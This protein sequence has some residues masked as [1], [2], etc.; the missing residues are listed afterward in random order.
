MLGS[1]ERQV[2]ESVNNCLRVGRKRSSKLARMFSCLMPLS[3]ALG[4][5]NVSRVL[6]LNKASLNK[7]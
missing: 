1:D 6:A 2:Y 5:Q 7:S 3:H 4:L